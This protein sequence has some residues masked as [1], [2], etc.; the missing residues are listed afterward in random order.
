M[1]TQAQ[2][3]YKM[4]NKQQHPFQGVHPGEEM[5]SHEQG[6]GPIHIGQGTAGKQAHLS[7]EGLDMAA[8]QPSR[9][10][11]RSKGQVFP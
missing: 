3:L 6:R 2:L 11:S 4:A 7:Q 8:W 9:S 5:N 1:G 10:I